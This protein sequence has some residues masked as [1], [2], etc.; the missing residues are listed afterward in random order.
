MSSWKRLLPVLACAG[1]LPTLSAC[2][3]P[4][5]SEP[6]AAGRCDPER[7]QSLVGKPKP[8]DA[9]AK[10]QSGAAIVRQI[11]PG[12]PVTQDFSDG[13][14]TVETDPATGLVVKVTCG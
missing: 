3:A 12:D 6:P 8:T 11:A 5:A 7:A 14:V 4:V 13:R 10:R 9:E 1:I 2:T